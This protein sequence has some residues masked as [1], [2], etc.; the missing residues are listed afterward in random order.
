GGCSGSFVSPEGLIITN[1][2]CA[3]SALQ[4]NSE[5]EDLLH[6]GFVART[7][8]D[9]RSNGPAARVFV[10]EAFTDVSDR[11]R[12]GIDAI[13]DDF[14][15]NERMEAREKAIVAECEKG[16]PE[17]RCSVVSYFGGESFVLIEQLEL[18]DIR[19]VYA[20]EAGVGNFGGEIDNW[21]WPRHSGDYAFF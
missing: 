3:T 20:P 17:I 12:E 8:A 21:R 18:R 15:R 7:R 13:Q 9:E 19:L 6:D 10:T 11:I 16:R 4:Y 14:A 2:H 5:K 1:H